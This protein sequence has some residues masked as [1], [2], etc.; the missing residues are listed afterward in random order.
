MVDTIWRAHERGGVRSMIVADAHDALSRRAIDIEES[1]VKSVFL[2]RRV[3]ERSVFCCSGRYDDLDHCRRARR[4]NIE[5]RQG[6][7]H[8]SLSGNADFFAAL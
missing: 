4:Y 5:C 6:A 8:A 2:M 1:F 7:V 3:V